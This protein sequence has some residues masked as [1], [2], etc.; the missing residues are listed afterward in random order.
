MEWQK[1]KK[2][3]P[4]R[5]ACYVVQNA[6]REHFGAPVTDYD[7][8]QAD[9]L[10][11]ARRVY[12]H[13]RAHGVR[14]DTARIDFQNHNESEQLIREPGE[15][16]GASGNCLELTLIFAA[17]CQWMKLR[18]LVVLLEGHALVAVMLDADAESG[19]GGRD[20]ELLRQG[21]L[22]RGANAATLLAW[23]RDK[24]CVLIE[25]TGVTASS[26]ALSFDEA[27]T[28]GAAVV[29]R[30][31]LVNVVDVSFLHRGTHP[32]YET[33]CAAPPAPGLALGPVAVAHLRDLLGRATVAEP[34]H[35]HRRALRGVQTDDRRLTQVL[36]DLG[37]A[38]SAAEFAKGW[39]GAELTS[40]R[41]R[42]VLWLRSKID[43]PAEPF[44]AWQDYFAHV[45]LHC[46]VTE[47]SESAL[48]GY[49]LALGLDAGL[50]G[51]D[52]AFG[53]WAESV[54]DAAVVNDVRVRV[55]RRHCTANLRLLLS[56]HDDSLTGE[57]PEQVSAW[58]LDGNELRGQ[59]FRT[60]EPTQ[61]HV[62]AAVGELLDWATDEVYAVGKSLRRLD[63]AV[64]TTLLT[65]W[66]PEEADIDT[67]LG[68][69]HDV[70]VRWSGRLNPPGHLRVGRHEARRRWE[71]LEEQGF[72][73]VRWLEQ[74]QSSDLGAVKT[75]IQQQHRGGMGLRFTPE[76][77]RGLL[78]LLLCY[79]P[80]LLWPDDDMCTWDGV[81]PELRQYWEFLPDALANAYRARWDGDGPPLAIM[82]A[83]WDDPAWLDF[84]RTA[85]SR[86]GIA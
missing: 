64:P 38:L 20:H 41:L 19:L 9:R 40:S 24:K 47:S 13:L 28:A 14:Y 59:D 31:E 81:E 37:R 53:T 66:R 29:S 39:L 77:H 82:R 23:V 67:M 52:Q 74:D 26:S 78:E 17:L 55:E 32:P 76:R 56:L 86:A 33:R 30:G 34:P 54:A 5:I 3:E 70:V 21:L 11:V 43:P 6:A 44:A 4:R 22:A 68:L 84:C 69:H 83:V 18:P 60:C 50:D 16:R 51:H 75:L 85:Q 1:W 79:T 35:W 57:W 36:D 15:V 73:G 72:S 2:S 25:C 45:V 7:E 27:L 42:S 49:V 46:P 80:V 63:I 61:R 12:D 71:V 8:R 58:L 10:A 65:Q 62:E 48:V